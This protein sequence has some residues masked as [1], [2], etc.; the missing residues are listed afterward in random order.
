VDFYFPEKRQLIQVARNMGNLTTCEREIRIISKRKGK[1][2]EGF[3][4]THGHKLRFP[5]SEKAQFVTECGIA[6]CF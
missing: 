6:I 5:P 4:N 1:R 2:P 3:Y